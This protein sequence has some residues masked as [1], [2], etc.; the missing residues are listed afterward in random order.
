VDGVVA[1]WLYESYPNMLA[2]LPDVELTGNLPP[3]VP[4]GFSGYTHRPGELME[5]IAEAELALEDL[6]GVEGMPLAAREMQA[7]LVD[8]LPG[9][10]C[11]TPRGPSN[12]FLNY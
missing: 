1:D 2:L 8:P 12:A 4:D 6:V 9:R 5:E 7:R 11:W 3:V 10:S